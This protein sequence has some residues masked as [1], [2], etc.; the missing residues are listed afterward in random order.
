MSPE[1]GPEER[2]WRTA[3]EVPGPEGGTLR[4][5]VRQPRGATGSAIVVCHGFKGFKDWGF[6]PYLA[7]RLVDR[8]ITRSAAA[9][10]PGRVIYTPWCDS[11][12]RVIDDGTVMRMDDGSW[13][14]TAAEGQYRWLT[15][16]ARGLDVEIEDVTDALGALAFDLP[17]P[18][19]L[20]LAAF[21][22]QFGLFLAALA[23]PLGLFLALA[24][25]LLLALAA[26]GLAL[27]GNEAAGVVSA[28][29][30]G[31]S[32]FALGDEVIGGTLN[33]TGTLVI[34][35]DQVGDQTVLSQI[36]R[37][38]ADAQRSRAPIQKLADQVAGYRQTLGIAEG[39]EWEPFAGMEE[40]A[41]EIEQLRR[42]LDGWEL[43]DD[44]YLGKPLV[45]CGTVGSLPSQTLACSISS[46]L[47]ISWSRSS[48]PSW[49]AQPAPEVRRRA[50]RAPGAGRPCRSR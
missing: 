33:Q 37:M 31:V 3:F 38:V 17:L 24:A 42:Q 34:R 47:A 40:R 10:K 48:S 2:W 44:R 9:V 50:M 8:V 27:L 29:G 5:D 41:G 28:V 1:D 16:N 14:W 12:G 22:L 32:G 25:C 30:P 20:R 39:D 36:I 7:E 35:A 4:G 18:F 46:P 11:D 45:F 43:F 49:P 21:A 15:L 19:E 23:F 13:F 6:F 26:L